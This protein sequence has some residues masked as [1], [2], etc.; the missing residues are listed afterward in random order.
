MKRHHRLSARLVLLFICV[1]ILIIF[2]VHSGFRYGI[3][4][5]FR[6]F[7]EPHMV[8]YVDHIRQQTGTPP[9]IIAATA[10]A[11]RLQL[12][13]QINFPDHRWSSNGKLVDEDKLNFHTHQLSNGRSVQVSYDEHRFLLRLQEE[14]IGLL[15]ISQDN[16]KGGRLPIIAITTILTILA[17]IALTYHL[18]RR[19]FQPIEIIRRDVARFGS[20]E[21]NHRISLKRRDELG[22]LANSINT[23]AEEI[24]GML[25]AKRQLLLAISHELRSPLTRVRLNA[26]LL[27][28]SDQRE[29]IISDLKILEHQLAELLET[30]QLES[31]HAKLDLQPVDPTQL[32]ES[33]KNEHFFDAL[34]QPHFKNAHQQIDLDPIRIKLLMRNLLENAL[35]HT[36]DEARP[37]EVRSEL[38]NEGWHLLVEDH[39]EGIPA[40]HISHLTE[41]FY[42]VD[43]ARQ[44]ATGGYGLGLYLCRIIVDAHDGRLSIESEPDK[45]T[46]IS[47]FIP[48]SE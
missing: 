47:I 12:D 7:A 44:R 2:V 30:E 22:E 35:R 26:E 43:Q 17:L 18:V 21:L 32:I 38:S 3:R 29:R 19:L 41:P 4:D 15:F 6:Q 42:R 27:S 23:M 48:I 39:G 31:K 25:D 16:W 9:D 1:S 13:I 37:V 10:L 33:V 8:E 36:P 45:G 14:D 11:Q 5:E 28:E 46:K 20:G 24:E 40:E 34:W